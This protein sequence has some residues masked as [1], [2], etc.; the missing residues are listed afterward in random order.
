MTFNFADLVLREILSIHTPARGV[1][2][3]ADYEGDYY[4]LFQSTLPQGE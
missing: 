3:E 2:V 1:T 4:W